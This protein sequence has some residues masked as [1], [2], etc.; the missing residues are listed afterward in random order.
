M[1]ADGWH[2]GPLLGFD[3]ETTGVTGAEDRIVTAAVVDGADVS[4]WLIDPGVEIPAEA[5][6]IHGITTQHARDHGVAPHL[7]LPE[8]ARILVKAAEERIPVVAYR[9]GFDLTL[10]A[11]ELERHGLEPV[12]WNRLY[13]IDPFVLDK[14]CDKW[15]KGKRTLSAVCE[16]YGVALSHAHS[17]VADATAAV[18]L[19]RAIGARYPKIAQMSLGELHVSQ[20]GWHADDAAS[21]EAY[22]RRQGRD[23]TVDRR[24]PLQL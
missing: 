23:E 11:Y 24:W 1:I 7:A 17:A 16:Q 2:T 20:M 4:T 12:P 9:A 22:L 18:A 21:L 6:R 15:R 14:K 5:T 19:A 10:L 8:I 3:T 13:V